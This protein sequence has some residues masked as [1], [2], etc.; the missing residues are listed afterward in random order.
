MSTFSEKTIRVPA[1]PHVLEANLNIPDEAQGVVVF[2]HGSG[3]G[4]LS[5][6][7]RSVA[8]TLFDQGMGTL[9]IDLLTE[10]EEK[11][12][13]LTRQYRFDIDLLA[14]RLIKIIDWLVSYSET[15]K[16]RIGCFGSST[17]AAAALIAAAERPRNVCAVV[18]RGGRPDMALHVLSEVRAPT[19]FVVGGNDRTVLQLNET[20]Y[21][22]LQTKKRLEIV[23]GASHLFEEP[24]ALETVASLAAEWFSIHLNRDESYPANERSCDFHSEQQSL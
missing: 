16:L 22:Q 23:P 20:A 15:D 7:N 4:R 3:S 2:A 21:N 1:G 9:L 24:G 17:G 6:R 19:L 14:K 10:S 5:T 11:I 13:F 8:R 18:S 12:D